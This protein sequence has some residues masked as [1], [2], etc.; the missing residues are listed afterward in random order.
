MGLL[1]PIEKPGAWLARSA[2]IEGRLQTFLHETLAH[3]RYA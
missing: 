3:P 1:F 2:P